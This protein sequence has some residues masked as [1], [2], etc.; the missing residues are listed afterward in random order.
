MVGVMKENRIPI[1]DSR[2]PALEAISLPGPHAATALRK[3]VLR[4]FLSTS[5]RI[6][7]YGV[8]HSD[9]CA[10]PRQSSMERGLCVRS[11]LL[12]QLLSLNY[13]WS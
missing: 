12:L 6:M 9:L 4:R 11:A 5:S 3:A 1:E 7:D 13:N 10:V 2:G 8:G